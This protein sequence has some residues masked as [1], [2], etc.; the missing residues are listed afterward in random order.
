[1]D[2]EDTLIE[3]PEGDL[4][5]NAIEKPKRKASEKQLA[6]LAAA[7]EKR[8]TKMTALDKA[9]AAVQ[10]QEQQQPKKIGKVV[11]LPAAAEAAEPIVL[12][13]PRAKRST[14]KPTIIQFE[15]DDSSSSGSDGEGGA[16]APTIIIRNGKKKQT[17]KKK[18]ESEQAAAAEAPVATGPRQ[19]IRRAYY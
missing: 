11:Q 18:E 9:A 6:A 3:L 5:T 8:K 7:R 16:P 4:P 13:K 12:K 10:V 17:T 1:M 19:Y 2:I 15:S 14:P